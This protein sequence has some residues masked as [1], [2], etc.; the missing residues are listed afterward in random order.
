MLEK[1]PKFLQPFFVDL[2]KRL[3]RPGFCEWLSSYDL[4][5]EK[6]SDEGYRNENLDCTT[7]RQESHHASINGF[8][9]PRK[10]A[11]ERLV[12][13]LRSKMI[14]HYHE[15]ENWRLGEALTKK[16]RRNTISNQEKIAR[17]VHFRRNLDKRGR[18]A[19][20][21]NSTFHRNVVGRCLLELQ[22][23]FE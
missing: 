14:L 12:P 1:S 8:F 23:I 20:Q 9:G 4:I 6:I 11:F 7:S 2:Q 3:N 5:T 16:Q 15:I 13:R 19:K 21:R 18:V 22:K 10:I 17:F